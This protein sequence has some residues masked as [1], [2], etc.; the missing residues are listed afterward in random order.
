MDPFYQNITSFPTVIYSFFLILAALYWAVAVLGVISIDVLDF[1][2][3]EADSSEGFDNG[4]VLAG[5]MMKFGLYGVPVTIIVSLIV[6]FGW[7]LSYY[8]VYFIFSLIPAGVLQWLIGIPIFIGTFYAAVLITSV[9][10]KPMRAL[11]K[12]AVQETVKY[13]L[14]QPAIVRTSRVDEGFGEAVMQ[15]GG[16][17]LILKVRSEKGT[18]FSKGDKVVLFEYL[19]E[20]NIYRVISEDDFNGK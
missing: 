17:G 19:E 1:D 16:A 5:L 7:I 10:I 8:S 3:P 4:N 15:D 6:L 11:F 9:L 2:L 13:V 12:S 20:K 14:G 18:T